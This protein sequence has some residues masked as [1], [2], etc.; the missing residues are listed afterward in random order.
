MTAALGATAGPSVRWLGTHHRFGAF[1][2]DDGI[3]ECTFRYVNDGDAPLR[4]TAARSSCG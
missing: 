3:V 4:I 1:H 2:E